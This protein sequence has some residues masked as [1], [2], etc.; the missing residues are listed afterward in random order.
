MSFQAEAFNAEVTCSI[1]KIKS[2]KK[3]L[4]LLLGKIQNIE[5]SSSCLE[6]K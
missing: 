6:R 1:F 2:K 3:I 5:Y 4:L